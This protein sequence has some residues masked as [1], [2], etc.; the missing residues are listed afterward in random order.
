MKQPQ[1]WNCGSSAVREDIL[2]ARRNSLQN[3]CR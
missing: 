1:W 3:H 2:I